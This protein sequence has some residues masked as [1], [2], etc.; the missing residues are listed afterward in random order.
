MKFVEREDIE[1]PIEYVFSQISDFPALERSAM[2]RGAEVQRVDNLGQNG[3]GMAWDTSFML[4]GKRRDMHL[5]MTDYDE[6][7]C[8]AIESNSANLAGYMM[9]D[10]VALS[11]RRTRLTVEVSVKPKTLTA[12]LLLQSLKLARTNMTRRFALRVAEYAKDVEDR[13]KAT[14]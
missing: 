5:E 7:N 10:L 1:A 11:R 12:R 13:F 8:L 6:P 9:I 3:I 2:R 14:A 4:R